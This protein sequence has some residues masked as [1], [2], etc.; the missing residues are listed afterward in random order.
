MDAVTGMKARALLT[1]GLEGGAAAKESTTQPVA[2]QPGEAG[3]AGPKQLS[4]GA[5]DPSGAALSNGAM[6]ENSSAL[7]C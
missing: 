7:H 3:D 5:A 1:A 2:A 6:P 4:A